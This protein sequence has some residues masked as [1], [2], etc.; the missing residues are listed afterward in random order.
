M[1]A[2]HGFV[3]SRQKLKTLKPEVAFGSV[4]QGA[5]LVKE[6]EGAEVTLMASGSELMLCLNAACD[7]EVEGI[8]AN[9]VSVPCLDLFNEQDSAYKS[10]VIKSNTKVLAVEAAT[11]T[12]YYRYAD[13]VL[14]M[15]SFGASAPA[16]LLFEKFGFTRKNIVARVKALV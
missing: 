14:G 10:E 3:L 4:A 9:V 13:D 7:L 16:N 11:A 6:R 8:K 12:E 5:Y 15:E 2:P 1:N